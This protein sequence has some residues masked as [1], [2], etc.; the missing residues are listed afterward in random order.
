M[1]YSV[2]LSMGKGWK[3]RSVV[4]SNVSYCVVGKQS[5]SHGLPAA[6]TLSSNEGQKGVR[7]VEGS[8]VPIGLLL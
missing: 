8:T 5:H 4:A 2:V 3:K 7:S 1:Q 6:V